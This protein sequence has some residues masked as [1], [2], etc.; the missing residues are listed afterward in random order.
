MRAASAQPLLVAVVVLAALAGC[1]TE[2]H[3]T[4][5]S[6]SHPTIVS[7]PV[8]DSPEYAVR[9]FQW[10]WNHRDLESFRRVLPGDFRFVFALADSSGNRFTNDPLGREEML[11]ILSG[12]FTGGGRCSP[13][14]SVV[15]LFDPVLRPIDDSRPGRNPRWHKGILT[16]VDLTLKLEDGEEYRVSGNAR[17][18]LVRGDSAVIPP[19]LAAEGVGPDSTRWYIQQWNDETLQGAGALSRAVPAKSQPARQTTWGS[20]LALYF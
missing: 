14:S 5:P 11:T 7:A 8:A 2:E 4:G 19:D 9:L 16:S 1:S 17:F 13:A 10:G 12:I 20:I 15:L 3:V 18:F 6:R